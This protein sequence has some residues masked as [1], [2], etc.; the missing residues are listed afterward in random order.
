MQNFFGVEVKLL[1]EILPFH[2][3]CLS[4]AGGIQSIC[5]RQAGFNRFVLL[6]IYNNRF[7]VKDFVFN[8]IFK[9]FKIFII[10]VEMKFYFKLNFCK[11]KKIFKFFLN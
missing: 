9:I 11:I 1:F 3:F 7:A 4:Q 2:I 10:N 8:E 5:F 6:W